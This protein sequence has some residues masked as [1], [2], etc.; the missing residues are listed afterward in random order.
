MTIEVLP[1]TG[2]WD[3]FASFMVP[4]KPGGQGCVCAL[5]RDSRLD[6]PGRIALMRDQC[7]ADP[8]PGVLAYVDGEVAAWC[9][10]A[11]KADFR[12]IVNSRTIPHIHDEGAWCAMC[13]VVRPP[14]RRQS[15]LHVLLDAAVAH[16]AAHGARLIEGYPVD[17]GGT[18]VDQISGY[19]GSVELFEAHGFRRVAQTT[20]VRGGR[21]RWLVQRALP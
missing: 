18:R 17:A 9:S 15:L 6:M 7:A 21:P 3:D 4:R 14:F 19:V 5:Y 1:A 13:F 8:G 10:V 12:G 2:H 20:G 16:A 11:T